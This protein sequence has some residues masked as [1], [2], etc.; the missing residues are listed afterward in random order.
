MAADY[1]IPVDVVNGT[2]QGQTGTTVGNTT[3][4][5]LGIEFTYTVIANTPPSGTRF[6]N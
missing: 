6:Y 3:T 5:S 2:I 1:Y 4:Y